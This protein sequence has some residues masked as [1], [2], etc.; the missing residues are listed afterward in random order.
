MDACP[1]GEDHR[2]CKITCKYNRF[3]SGDLRIDSWEV[4]CL[5]CGLRKTIAMRSDEPDEDQRPPEVCPFCDF[6]AT[7]A[8]KDLCTSTQS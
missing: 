1:H 8:G 3:E 4:K 6:C 2:D 7:S 5:D